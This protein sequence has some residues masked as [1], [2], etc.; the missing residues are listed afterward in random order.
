MNLV[1]RGL[2]APVN[3]RAYGLLRRSQARSNGLMPYVRG[4][5]GSWI[6]SSCI[7][8]W[9]GRGGVARILA[10]PACALKAHMDSR[11]VLRAFAACI[12]DFTSCFSS[13]GG[14]IAR[15]PSDL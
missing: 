9:E 2:E 4:P 8:S 5:G 1:I 6:Q 12:I 15:S 7:S 3:D 13:G 10:I 14:R 11:R